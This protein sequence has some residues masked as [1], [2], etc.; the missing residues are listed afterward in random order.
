MVIEIPADWPQR[1][2]H[3]N[4]PLGH[5]ETVASDAPSGTAP[6]RWEVASWETTREISS[7]ALPGQVRHKTGLSVGTG[8]ALVKRDSADYPWRMRDVYALTGSAA[9]ILIAPEG[10]TEIPTGQ[11]RVA[12]VEGDITTL[13]VEVDLDERQIQGR[14]KAANVLGDQW[15]SSLSFADGIADPAWLVS[16]LAR[17]MGYGVTAEPNRD[18][19]VPILDV[20]LQGSLSPAWPRGIDFRMQSGSPE[21]GELDGI[22]TLYDDG[23]STVQFARYGIE[24]DIA[25]L[26]TL[27]FDAYDRVEL[28]WTRSGQTT[29]A[30][31]TLTVHNR[32]LANPDQFQVTMS[33][34]GLNGTVNASTG[35]VTYTYPIPED[36][37]SGIQVQVEFTASAGGTNWNSARFR[38]RRGAGSAWSAWSAVH[39]FT[40]ALSP[41]DTAY[42]FWLRPNSVSSAEAH[43]SRV[44]LVDGS[45]SPTTWTDDQ[46]WAAQ[47]LDQ[48][49]RL[50][51]E[52]LF[53]TI[54]S[55][56][57]DPDLTVLN[58]MQ[59]IVQAWQGA[60][61]TDVYGD[62]H[63][64]NRFTLSGVA[65]GTEPILDV[66]LNF[67]DLPWVMDYADQADRL[68]VKYR[69]ARIAASTPNAVSLPTLWE[70]SDLVTVPANSSVDVF[71]TLDYVYPVDLL[72]IEFIRRGLTGEA[73]A[74]TWDA[75]PNSDGT[76]ASA[77]PE[78]GMRLQLDRVSSSTWK[79]KITNLTGSALHMVDN[80]GTPY[81]K[82]RSSYYIDQTQEDTV[83]RGLS[84]SDAQNALEIDL[85]NYVQNEED[86]DTL[87]DFLW[88][89]VNRRVWRAK[90]VRTVPDYSID[91]GDIR[92]IVHSRT[93]VQSN[94]LVSKVKL[95]GEPGSV[96][97]ELD[98]ILI[99]PTWEDFDEAWGPEY[100]TSPPGSWAEFD[101]LWA[102]YT[103]DDFDRA[104]TATTVAE[105]EEGM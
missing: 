101:A 52:P 19:Y 35:P 86:A 45:G 97:Q 95:A 43:L 29:N 85:S 96:T 84:S 17:Q 71:F 104:P 100:H 70:L 99:P 12:P 22:V 27:T 62:L 80:T 60:L 53:G 42:N 25:V 64:L 48:Q 9:Q 66:G 8:K 18:G 83:E 31:V 24:R 74:H 51:L 61:I 3:E 92:E 82:I 40:N 46:L 32:T 47:S 39:A 88:A 76:G 102:P 55:P 94:V 4:T 56:W 75:H 78:T 63:L 54:R 10:A 36:R 41:A 14:D 89:R 90:T 57:L 91:L 2:W 69:P 50:Y 79:I 65:T 16:E 5:L 11:F 6:T 34:R 13:G 30:T 93:R 103:W 81:L 26:N 44:S 59:A 98:L 15:T 21:W 49:G 58:A 1:R 77:D 38:A 37:P 73:V 67:E 7:S 87:A 33:S 20:P 105:I 28:Q 68:V 72:I 23:T